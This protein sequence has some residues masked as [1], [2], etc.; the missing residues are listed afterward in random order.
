MMFIQFQ[1]EQMSEYS[2]VLRTNCGCSQH[3]FR[4]FRIARKISPRTIIE[5]RQLI[6]TISEIGLNTPHLSLTTVFCEQSGFYTRYFIDM[7]LKC[8]FKTF[9]GRS[10]CN[11]RQQTWRYWEYVWN[12]RAAKHYRS[13]SIF[14]S[15]FFLSSTTILVCVCFL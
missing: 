8:I 1:S 4:V 14:T 2:N 6:P 12:F 5:K 13:L 7:C 10:V 3:F 15:I 11:L 9:R